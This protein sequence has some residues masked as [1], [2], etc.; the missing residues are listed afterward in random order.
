MWAVSLTL[1][2][3]SILL[4]Y[5]R[6]FEV[7]GFI[8]S[9]KIAAVFIGMWASAVILSS[10]LLCRPFAFNW[11]Q[12]IP[13]GKCSNQVLSYQITGVL[14][15]VTDVVVLLLPMPYIW[16]L[17][18]RLSRKFALTALFSVGILCVSTILK[19]HISGPPWLSYLGIRLTFNPAFVS[20][21][22]F[23]SIPCPRLT[24]KT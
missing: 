13:G 14:N 8:V 7:Q 9:A 4:F 5:A 10:F 2:K 15:L 22:S 6:I 3:V 23:A 11:D 20:S 18:L 24:T 19:F 12:T 1:V 16:N 17:Q 21:P